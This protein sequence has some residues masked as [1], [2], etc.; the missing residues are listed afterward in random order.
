MGY[1]DIVKQLIVVHFFGVSVFEGNHKI[2]FV[3]GD[4]PGLWE[5]VTELGIH[6]RRVRFDA[7][8][9]QFVFDSQQANKQY[10]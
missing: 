5:Q 2:R 3:D 10:E 1:G 6:H 9:R 7:C 8:H 4:T